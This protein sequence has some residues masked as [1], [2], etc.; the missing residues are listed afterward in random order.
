MCYNLQSLKYLIKAQ[1]LCSET[2]QARS[3]CNGDGPHCF[4]RNPDI[5]ALS[6]PEH[7]QRAHCTM[8]ISKAVS[9]RK[10]KLRL[11]ADT[12]EESYMAVS[13]CGGGVGYPA[14]RPL[15]SI[16]AVSEAR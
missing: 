9:K 6:C 3:H 8:R 13:V 4:R 10:E 5:F 7:I 12:E 11:P 16:M 2:L 15:R 14:A 1:I